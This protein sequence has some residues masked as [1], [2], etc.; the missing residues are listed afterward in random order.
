[1][2]EEQCQSTNDIVILICG[3]LISDTMQLIGCGA[4]LQD[5]YMHSDYIGLTCSFSRTAP[6][7][8]YVDYLKWSL[9]VKV[10]KVVVN[11]GICDN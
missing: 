5:T 2:T 1:M 4:F 8:A 3:N 9:T 6:L 10:A 7:S 11:E